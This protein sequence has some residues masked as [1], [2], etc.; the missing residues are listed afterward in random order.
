MNLTPFTGQVSVNDLDKQAL[1]SLRGFDEQ[2]GVEIIEKYCEADL[3]SIRNKTGFF[4]GIIK[5]YRL[6]AP[7]ASSHD[8][9]QGICACMKGCSA[10]RPRCS[11]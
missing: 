1:D 6:Q 8:S 5:R 4:V 9:T 3:T 2:T 7:T 11:D 10:S